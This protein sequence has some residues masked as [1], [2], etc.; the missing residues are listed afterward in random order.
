MIV[1]EVS[2]GES[3]KAREELEFLEDDPD[4]IRKAPRVKCVCGRIGYMQY[5]AFYQCWCG[6]KYSTREVIQDMKSIEEQLNEQKPPLSQHLELEPTYVTR[7]DKVPTE[8]PTKG[9]GWYGDQL[10]LWRAGRLALV[11]ETE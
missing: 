7:S 6:I 1:Q 4:G 9:A 11:N 10:W 3:S 8:P 5:P 2:A